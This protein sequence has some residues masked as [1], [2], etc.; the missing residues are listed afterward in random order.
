MKSKVSFGSDTKTPPR[1]KPS[2]LTSGVYRP[3][4]KLL[5]GTDYKDM[6]LVVLK[7]VRDRLFVSSDGHV[8][9]AIPAWSDDTQYEYERVA[10]DTVIITFTNNE[11]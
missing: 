4:S 3:I 6:R 8:A 7:N 10:D 9:V 1:L 11:K 5:A 2:Q